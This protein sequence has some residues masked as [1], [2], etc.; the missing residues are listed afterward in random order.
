MTL[1]ISGINKSFDGKRILAGVSLEVGDGEIVALIG[2]SG[3]GKSTLLR[4]IC[5]LESADDGE[6]ML[7]GENIDEIPCEKRNIGMI[8]QSP[9]LYPHM[10]VAR[11]LHLG[12]SEKMSREE[13][14][15]LV[16]RILNDVDLAGFQLRNVDELSGG[17]AQR[18]ALARTLLTKPRA[19]L[20]D[21]P[22]SA[23]DTELRESLA[24]KT[25][26]LL[27]QLDI[28]IIHVT[29]DVDEA[30]RIADRVVRLCDINIL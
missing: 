19:L 5:G 23:L 1:K 14:D 10:N 21:E 17:E 28:P 25:R 11:N 3:S 2:A 15:E 13:K 7:A 20:M 6:V 16:V 8:F 29:H 18:V 22:F 26:I 30:Q 12:I 24:E 9:I 27:S 4:I